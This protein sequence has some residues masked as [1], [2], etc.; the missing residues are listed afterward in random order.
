MESE[1]GKKGAEETEKNHRRKDTRESELRDGRG[2][3][4]GRLEIGIRKRLQ[5]LVMMVL[6]QTEVGER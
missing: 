6:K 4:A 5:Y 2:G 3:S 1:S